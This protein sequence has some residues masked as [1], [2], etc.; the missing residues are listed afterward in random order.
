MSYISYRYDDSVGNVKTCTRD[1]VLLPL[2]GQVISLNFVS[3]HFWGHDSLT[4]FFMAF[5][6][7]LASP[8]C[9]CYLSI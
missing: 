7:Q 2:V 5:V 9:L 8:K 1:D 4:A 3:F 6:I